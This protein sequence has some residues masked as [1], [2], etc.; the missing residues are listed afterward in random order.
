MWHWRRTTRGLRGVRVPHTCAQVGVSALPET[1]GTL[2]TAV[3]HVQFSHSHPPYSDS[4]TR[5]G[6][7][8]VHTHNRAIG[9]PDPVVA[10]GGGG[11][12][13]GGGGEGR[14]SSTGGCKVE[15]TDQ[16][17]TNFTDENVQLLYFMILDN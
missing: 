2:V 7:V 13:G 15:A 9:G 1:T 14:E 16:Q 6:H 5:P 4:T 10:R 3:C 11:G 8:T 12:G 17:I